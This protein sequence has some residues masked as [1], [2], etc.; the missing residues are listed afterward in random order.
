MAM[1]EIDIL[2][3]ENSSPLERRAVETLARGAMAIFRSQRTVPA[4]FVL[5]APTVTSSFP[6]GFEILIFVV[7]AVGSAVLPLILLAMSGRA[8]L[9]LVGLIQR[10]ASIRLAAISR[11]LRHF[12]KLS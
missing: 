12:S 10:L 9:V 6:L 1:R 7:D 8:R 11:R 3:V 5:Y 4:E 2:L